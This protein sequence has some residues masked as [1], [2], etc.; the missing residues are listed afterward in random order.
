MPR[1]SFDELRRAAG[2]EGVVAEGSHA[3]LIADP[4]AFGQLAIH[5]LVDSGALTSRPNLRLV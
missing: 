1:S 3:W 4:E 5:A 2:V